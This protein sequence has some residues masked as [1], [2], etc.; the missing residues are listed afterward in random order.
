MPGVK[1]KAPLKQGYTTSLTGIEPQ[2]AVPMADSAGYTPEEAQ[3]EAGRC[4][5][6]ECMECVKNC[7]YL[8]HFKGPSQKIRPR[9]LQQRLHCLRN[10]DH[11]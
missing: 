1:R 8:E 4:I 11:E 2:P 3:A 5:Q 9:G 6:C 10:A 7:L